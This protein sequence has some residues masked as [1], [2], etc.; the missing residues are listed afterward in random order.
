MSILSQF[1]QIVYNSVVVFLLCLFTLTVQLLKI[2]ALATNAF[3]R[4]LCLSQAPLLD[5][6][7]RVRTCFLGISQLKNKHSQILPG[8]YLY[9]CRGKDLKAGH[10]SLFFSFFCFC[11][12]FV[13]FFQ[14]KV[15]RFLHQHNVEQSLPMILSKKA[16]PAGP[17]TYQISDSS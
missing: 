12:M 11:F 6:P 17:P 7:W 4:P 2:S 14:K 3:C 15:S 9:I 16:H 10:R 13:S 5:P 8:L 1:E